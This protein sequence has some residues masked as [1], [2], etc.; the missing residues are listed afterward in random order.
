MEQFTRQQKERLTFLTAL[1]CIVFAVGLILN[2]FSSFYSENTG[3]LRV[4]VFSDSPWDESNGF[5]HV[6]LNEAISEF[7]KN[8]YLHSVGTKPLFYAIKTSIA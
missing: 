2:P 3:I 7:E 1:M 6:I 5:A 4:G 8:P